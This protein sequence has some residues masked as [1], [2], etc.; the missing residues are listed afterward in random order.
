MVASV[1]TSNQSAYPISHV[2]WAWKMGELLE[3]DGTNGIPTKT[4][5]ARSGTLSAL[6]KI[7][8]YSGLILAGI[9]GLGYP[10]LLYFYFHLGLPIE[11]ITHDQYLKAGII[12]F[13]GLLLSAIAVRRLRK[14]FGEPAYAFG[15]LLIIIILALSTICLLASVLVSASYSLLGVPPTAAVWVTATCITLIIGRVLICEGYSLNKFVVRDVAWKISEKTFEFIFPE[16]G[17]NPGIGDRWLPHKV[18]LRSLLLCSITYLEIR[19]FLFL[20]HRTDQSHLLTALLVTLCVHI[21][22]LTAAIGLTSEDEGIISP[23]W[24]PFRLTYGDA[25]SALLLLTF[26]IVLS[27]IYTVSLYPR[28]PHSLGGGAP[29]PVQISIRQNDC[30]SAEVLLTQISQAPNKIGVGHQ[31]DLIHLDTDYVI[32]SSEGNSSGRSAAVSRLCVAA[33]SPE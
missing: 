10:A 5:G 24:L 26:Y 9:V 28:L 20:S 13:V 2:S 33:L 3:A 14:R 15:P 11:L 23:K 16:L 25:N 18:L 6:D 19:L 8:S 7:V 4:E 32:V 22:Y 21:G 12:P 31:V 17:N 1:L 29:E 30:L 27:V